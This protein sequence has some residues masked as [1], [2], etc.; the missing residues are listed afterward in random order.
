MVIAQNS[1]K[2]GKFIE[3][4]LLVIIGNLCVIAGN[5]FVITVISSENEKSEIST[6]N[7]VIAQNCDKFRKFTE[8]G[9]LVIT[10]NLP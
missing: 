1:D 4:G 3:I 2:L 10:G 6:L 7:M 9:L 8:I 5:L